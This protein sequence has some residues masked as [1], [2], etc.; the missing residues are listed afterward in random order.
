MSKSKHHSPE[1]IVRK[2]QIADRLAASGSVVEVIARELGVSVPTL[3]NWRKRYDSVTVSE[4]K[5]LKRL[6]NE[7][8]QLKV[9]C[10]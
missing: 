8:R 6:R 7:N 9:A 5:E 4:A 10:R 3:Y 2:L 1:Q